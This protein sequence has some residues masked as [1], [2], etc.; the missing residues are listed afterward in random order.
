MLGASKGN[1]VE[2]KCSRPPQDKWERKQN[3]QKHTKV[4]A[5]GY[6][7]LHLPMNLE[8]HQGAWHS[9][10]T[11]DVHCGAMIHR[12]RELAN[13]TES[14][15]FCRTV[16]LPYTRVEFTGKEGLCCNNRVRQNPGTLCRRVR[17]YLRWTNRAM[18]LE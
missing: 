3:N 2:R 12:P 16:V 1:P 10:P 6:T 17:R 18:P 9:E 13:R 5:A 15:G 8:F 14:P 4:R 11:G 7:A